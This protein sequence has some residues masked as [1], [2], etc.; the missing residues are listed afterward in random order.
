MAGQTALII[1]RNDMLH[2]HHQQN[3]GN[4]TSRHDP[5][6]TWNAFQRAH[7]GEGTHK[8]GRQEDGLSHV[9]SESCLA[10]CDRSTVSNV[11]ESAAGDAPP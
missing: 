1:V 9:L 6:P 8:T 5:G 11:C 2:E 3:F 4:Y 10:A 7:Q